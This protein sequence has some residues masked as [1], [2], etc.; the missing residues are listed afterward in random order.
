MLPVPDV[1]SRVFC[2]VPDQVPASVCGANAA[3]TGVGGGGGGGCET[4]KRA[5]TRL[6]TLRP[7]LQRGFV[8]DLQPPAQ[9]ANLHPTAGLAVSSTIAPFG[10]TTR[11]FRGQAIPA[12]ELTTVPLPLTVTVRL[13]VAAVEASALLAAVTIV[14]ARTRPVTSD[15][16][17][18][19]G[20]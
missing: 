4:V 9:P 16:R 11:H 8:W 3:G 10:R 15:R 20:R 6:L 18:I 14:A 1:P 13:T 2:H 17:G 7:T 19:A 5:R 12:G